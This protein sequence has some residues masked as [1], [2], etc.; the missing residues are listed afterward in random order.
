MKIIAALCSA[1]IWGSGQLINKQIL[2]GLVFFLLQSVLVFVELSTGTLNVLMGV[3]EP[4]FRNCGYFTKGLW[5]LIT[6]GEIPRLGSA[7]LVYDH[8]ILLMIGGIISTMV[9]LLFIFVWIWNIRDAYKSRMVIEQGGKVSSVQYVKN[10][11]ERSFEYIMIT[12]GTILVLFISVIPVLFSIA[13]AF[14]NYN[15]NA[16]PPRFIIEWVGF[17]TFSDIMNIP[18]WSSTFVRVLV[19][20][21]CW[22][23]ISTLTAYGLGLLQAV[24]INAKG[25]RFKAMWRGILILPW[26]V[27]TMVS[28]LIFRTMFHREGAF[29]QLLM[30]SGIISEAIPFLS[31]T[32]WAR[33][34]VILVNMW[35]SFPFYMALISGVMTSISPELYEAVEIDGGNS[36]H[37]FR[38]ISM[39]TILTA[40]SPLIVMGITGNFNSFSTIFFITEGGPLNPAYQMAG[41]TDLLITWIFKLTLDQRMY[42]Y[43]SAISILIFIVIAAITAIN[44]MRTRAFKEE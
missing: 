27:P 6:L 33:T 22:A 9:L 12:P 40:T 18:I 1:F 16:I 38:Y 24:L 28:L 43:A 3:I 2:K 15:R 35:L 31:N 32:F 23:F 8:S 14:T 10:L 20:T 44:L 5:G 17:R 36:W 19:W 34:V 21:V 30:N 37:K 7:T 25:I 26:A 41:T 42:N 4:T 39:P 11:W 29:N 13:V